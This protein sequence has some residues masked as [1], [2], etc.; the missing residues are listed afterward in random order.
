MSESQVTCKKWITFHALT[1][2][3][4]QYYA[5]LAYTNCNIYA[6]QRELAINYVINSLVKKAQSFNITEYEACH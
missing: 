5:L 1:I 2:H 4:Q 3:Y 6:M